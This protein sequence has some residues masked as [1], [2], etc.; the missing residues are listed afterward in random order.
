[1][2]YDKT[3]GCKTSN[4]VY[5]IWCAKCK[6]VVYVGQT[7]DT[8]YKRTHN[9]LSSIRCKRQGRIP[10]NRHFSVKEHGEEDFKI[11]G[12]ERTWGNSDF[13]GP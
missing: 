12:L 7:G 4:L 5:G 13:G 10:V 8:I 11:I 2:H 6:K 1:M 3:I 9:H